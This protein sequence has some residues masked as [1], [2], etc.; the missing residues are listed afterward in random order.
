MQPSAW[1]EFG[2]FLSLLIVL[3]PLLG[4]VYARVLRGD[5]TPVLSML[6]PVEKAIYRLAGIDDMREMNWREYSSCVLWFSTLGIITVTIL[7]L[8][9]NR[10]PLNPQQVGPVPLLPALNTAISFVTN[11]NWQAYSGENTLSYLV[12]TVG[13]TVQNFVSAAT[14]IAVMTALAKGISRRQNTG[15]GS[16]WVDLVRTVLYILLPLSIIVA[17]IL[18]GQ[19]VIQNFSHYVDARTIEGSSQVLPMGPAASQIAIKQ[20]GTNGGG[21]F[22]VNSAH[23]FENPTPFS[24]FIEYL[25]ILLMPSVLVYSFGVLVNKRLHGITLLSAMYMILFTAIGISLWSEMQANPALG[26]LPFMEGKEVR[27][28]IFPSALWSVLTTVAS[29]GSVNAMHDSMSPLSGGVAIFNMMLGEVVFGGVGSGVY[30]IVLFAVLTVFI[31]GL[32]VGRT[33]EYLGKKIETKDVLY[34]VI[35][36]LLPCAVVLIFTSLSLVLPVGLSSLLNK[37]PHGLS[38]VLYAFTSAANNNGSAFAGLNVSTPYYLILTSLAMLLGRFGVIVPVLLLAESLGRKKYTPPSIGTFPTE[39]SLFAVLLIGVI[40]IIGALTFF[41]A[42]TLGP[43]IE[44]FL[45]LQG[46]VF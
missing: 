18:V 41:P 14:G 43:I 39:S 32:M 5:S 42:L 11:T 7:Q 40:I 31:A 38:E 16:F 6:K 1:I 3:T 21:F 13:L 44:H 46:R 37:G 35:G 22:G 17:V 4:E 30:G 33:P 19:G 27:F 23:P 15:L 24:N 9:Q 28:G 36:I 26:G 8:I 20:L 2:V 45:M 25:S 12:Q 10:L 34:A 29:N